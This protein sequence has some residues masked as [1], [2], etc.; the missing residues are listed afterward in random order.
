MKR[1]RTQ[2]GPAGFVIAIVALICAL[3]GG[4]YAA[5]GALTGKQ[6]KEVTKIAKKYAGKPGA[7]GP[8]GSAGAPGTNGKDGA[9]G[10]KGENGTNGSNGVNGANGK[11]VVA[12]D[13]NPGTNCTEGGVKFEVEGNTTKHFACNGGEGS[14]WTAGGALPSEATETGT[15]W[16]QG[17][18]SEVAASTINFPIPLS[19]ADAASFTASQILF[20]TAPAFAAK[21]TG[22]VNAPAAE[23]GFL[24]MY[25]SDESTI[26]GPQVLRP[27]FGGTVGVGT[28]GALLYSPFLTSA[29]YAGGSFAIT[30]P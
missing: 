15:W 7:P 14:P 20:P 8:T 1:I 12:T 18:G 17:N 11:S 28:S 4:A 3:A 22:T 27:D 6:K 21:C 9:P 13:E 24:C 25:R 29:S 30:A 19:S 23:P 26:T 2:L 16:F 10:A 5:S